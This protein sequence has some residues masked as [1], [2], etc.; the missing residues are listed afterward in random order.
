M[1]QN[2]LNGKI[3]NFE[4]RANIAARIK[5]AK[6][7]LILQTLVLGEMYSL[8]SRDVSRVGIERFYSELNKAIL[9]L[10]SDLSST[11]TTKLTKQAALDTANGQQSL[12]FP[13]VAEA[14][15]NGNGLR[16]SDLFEVVK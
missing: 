1:N 16:S 10:T 11:K 5:L 7:G 9:G 8:K 12:D 13:T 15:L 6:L 4:L 2:N 3:E 14:K